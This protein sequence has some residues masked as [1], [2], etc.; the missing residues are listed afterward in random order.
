MT[1]ARRL[2]HRAPGSRINAKQRLT[3]RRCASPL[4]T[5][6]A[7]EQEEEICALQAIL[8]DDIDGASRALPVERA[9]RSAMR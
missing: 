8:M 1:G 2:A 7:A 9:H 4:P 3:P 6:H 5:D